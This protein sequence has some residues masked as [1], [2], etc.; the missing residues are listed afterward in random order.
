M[1]IE[2]K[3]GRYIHGIWFVCN[4]SMDWMACVWRD[5]KMHDGKWVLTYRHRYYVDT[6][7][8]DSAD[9][10]SWYEFLCSHDDV[11]GVQQDV[12]AMADLIRQTMPGKGQT[13]AY[14]AL[15][16]C[17]GGDPS[18]PSK[19]LG[20]PWMHPKQVSKEEAAK[21]GLNLDAM[22]GGAA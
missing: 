19:M 17:D 14:F 21:M 16:E 2:F 22:S 8:F 1:T 3:P 11:A 12:D 20:H 9:R 6:K 7:A 5:P 15:F 10:K 4:K 18:I 13:E